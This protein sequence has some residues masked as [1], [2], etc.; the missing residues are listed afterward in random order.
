M[1]TLS[2]FDYFIR[3]LQNPDGYNRSVNANRGARKKRK[4]QKRTK[5]V[6]ESKVSV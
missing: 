2:F 3:V 5:V 6:T 4:L 1:T